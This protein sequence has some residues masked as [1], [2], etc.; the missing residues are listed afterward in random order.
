MLRM[1]FNGGWY[2]KKGEEIPTKLIKEEYERVDVPHTYNALDGQDGGDNYYRGYATYVKEFIYENDEEYP[3]SQV[4]E[5]HFANLP[6]GSRF[7][8]LYTRERGISE[9]E[10]PRG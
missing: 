1:L 9:G 5:S 10:R 4:V 3:A 2:F 7:L 6:L 8:I